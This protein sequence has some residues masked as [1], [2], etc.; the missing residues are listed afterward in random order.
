VEQ[1]EQNV[2]SLFNSHHQMKEQLTEILAK[3]DTLSSNH[4]EGEGSQN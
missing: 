4:D 1:L 2:G 3:L